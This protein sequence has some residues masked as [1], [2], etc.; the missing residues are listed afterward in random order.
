M[1]LIC[2]VLAVGVFAMLVVA[3]LASGILKE[4]AGTPRM[5]EIAGYIREATKAFVRRQYK[6]IAGFIV[7]LTIPLAIFDYRIAVTFVLGAVASLLAAYIGLHVAVEAN[8]RTA[9]AAGSSSSRAF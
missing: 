9:N 3:Y 7:L 4:S 5:I 8:V 6:T 2:V 1:D